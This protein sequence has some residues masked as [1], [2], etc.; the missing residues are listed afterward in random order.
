MTT[1]YP[2]VRYNGRAQYGYRD[3]LETRPL[4][5]EWQAGEER[6]FT[7]AYC[8]QYGRQCHQLNGRPCDDGDACTCWAAL[9]VAAWNLNSN[10]V[11]PHAERDAQWFTLLDP[12]VDAAPAPAPATKSRKTAPAA[13]E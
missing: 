1:D 10:G 8:N 9:F 5:P 4:S 2:R 11:G 13:T 12:A 3:S 7:P 6:A